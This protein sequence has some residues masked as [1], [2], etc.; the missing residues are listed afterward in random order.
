MGML[1]KELGT[2]GEELLSVCL[3]ADTDNFVLSIIYSCGLL[4]LWGK[5]QFPIQYGALI[6]SSSW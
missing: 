6:L 5:E 1:G 4:Q 3:V 2:L